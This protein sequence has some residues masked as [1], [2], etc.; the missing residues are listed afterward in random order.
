MLHVC[1]DD[2]V[3]PRV[4]VLQTDILR[5][6]TIDEHEYVGA[7]HEQEARRHILQARFQSTQPAPFFVGERTRALAARAD[8]GLHGIVHRSL[9]RRRRTYT[10]PHGLTDAASIASM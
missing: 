4:A 1:E 10:G 5:R 6:G 7:L 3:A 8:A 2:P 9:R